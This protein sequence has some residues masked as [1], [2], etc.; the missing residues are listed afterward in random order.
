MARSPIAKATFPIQD[1]GKPPA[2]LAIASNSVNYQAPV[3]PVGIPSQ[4]LERRLDISGA[5]RRVAKS[6][7]LQYCGL[8][9]VAKPVLLGLAVRPPA[10]P[11]AATPAPTPEWIPPPGRRGPW[12]TARTNLLVAGAATPAPAPNPFAQRS[13]SWEEGSCDASHPPPRAWI[14]DTLATLRRVRISTAAR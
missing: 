2:E 11:D 10:I 1:T 8:V 3:N 9:C 7:K 12:T 4:L 14:K 6:G 5:E 13:K